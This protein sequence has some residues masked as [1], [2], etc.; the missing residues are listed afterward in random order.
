VGAE[1][2]LV[3]S[4]S[5]GSFWLFAA[6]LM[7][8]RR[9]PILDRNADIPARRRLRPLMTQ[10]GHEKPPPCCGAHGGGLLSASKDELPHPNVMCGRF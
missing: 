4:L 2:M 5:N 7:A 6:V 8:R 9:R 3:V 1:S 10:I